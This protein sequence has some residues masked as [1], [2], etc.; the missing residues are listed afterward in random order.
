VAEQRWIKEIDINPLL[1]S[2]DRLIAVDARVVAYEAEVGEDALPKL[3]VRPYPTQYVA[4]WKLKNDTPVTIRPIRPEDEPLL[5][6]FH[7]TL[8][9]HSVY[10]RYFSPL[11]LSQRVAHERLTR[12]C[13]VD[14]DREMALVVEHRDPQSGERQVLAVG[15]L[16][17]LRGA[18]EAEYA[19]LVNDQW[20][21]QG[22]GSELLSRLIQI[23]RDERVARIVADILPDNQPMQRISKQLGFKLHRSASGP[24]RAVLDL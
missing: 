8:S 15:R 18:N 3:A 14:Y 20:Q 13:F 21:G 1:A 23:G 22:I 10:M 9:E 12:I 19:I 5:V 6:K 2:P 24:V 16:V 7:E 11:K 4:A 17:K